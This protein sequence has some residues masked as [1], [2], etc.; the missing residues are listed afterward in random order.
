MKE[1]KYINF[2][3]IS[4]SETIINYSSSSGSEFLTS[5]GSGST[6]QK[7]T[8][9]MVPVPFPVPQ[10]CFKRMLCQE[11]RANLPI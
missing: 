4:G 8:V 9:P 5:Y 10:H 2:I 7:V 1:I 11:L 3:S 6:R